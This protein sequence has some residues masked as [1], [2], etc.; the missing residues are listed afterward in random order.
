M[1]FSA[2]PTANFSFLFICRTFQRII[3]AEA[4]LRKA[5][6]LYRCCTVCGVETLCA[7]FARRSPDLRF[8]LID[9]FIINSIKNVF[10]S[11]LNFIF[12]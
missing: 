9:F 6:R 7:G 5:M 4:Q 10:Q 11:S 3:H 8:S 1:L 2:S 12:T